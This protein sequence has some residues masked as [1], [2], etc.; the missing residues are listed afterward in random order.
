MSPKE[1]FRNSDHNVPSTQHINEEDIVII[2][3]K[4][5]SLASHITGSFGGSQSF[6]DHSKPQLTDPLNVT[7]KAI[8]KVPKILN[9]NNE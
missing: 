8:T 2:D 5:Q 1:A 4:R 7:R 9:Y 3:K 6:F